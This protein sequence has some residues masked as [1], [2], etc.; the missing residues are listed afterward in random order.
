[1]HVAAGLSS[2]CTSHKPGF[3]PAA[4]LLFFAAPKKPKEG[5]GGK[6]ER[7]KGN[8]RVWDIFGVRAPIRRA[9][10]SPF[11]CSAMHR[12]EMGYGLN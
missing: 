10:G 1:M 2:G 12:I 6:A 7:R 5:K 11:G 9:F 4:D 8:P 3:A